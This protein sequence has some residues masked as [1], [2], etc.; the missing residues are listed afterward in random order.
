MKNTRLERTNVLRRRMGRRDVGQKREISEA[1][2]TYLHGKMMDAI[3]NGQSEEVQNILSTGFGPNR[4]PESSRKMNTESPIHMAATKGNV[5]MLEMFKKAGANL[6]QSIK[7]CI[8][9]NTRP[10]ILACERS[11]TPAATYLI[12]Q[13]ASLEPEK[14]N[15]G[16][17]HA[18][19]SHG[20][21]ALAKRLVKAGADVNC[22]DD[23][24]LTPLHQA[25]MGAH[26]EVVEWLLEQG[27]NPHVSNASN[28]TPT[29]LAQLHMNRS[30]GEKKTRYQAVIRLLEQNGTHE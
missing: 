23:A 10:L 21:L 17:L 9:G 12:A 7:S 20:N 13:G 5:E 28:Y 15:W 27:A 11:N 2:H 22:A 3:E 4:M 1:V 16:P 24:G 14:N 26:P 19:A 6:D 29:R 30:N 18:T 8:S 25:A